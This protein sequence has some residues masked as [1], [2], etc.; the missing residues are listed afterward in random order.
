MRHGPELTSRH[1]LS[2]CEERKIQLIHTFSQDG[3]CRTSML[4]VSNGY[5]IS[6]RY[7]ISLCFAFSD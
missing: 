1:F 4:K 6:V 2:W 5:E 7:H 3:R